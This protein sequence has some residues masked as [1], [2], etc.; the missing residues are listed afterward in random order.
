MGSE[1]ATGALA[2]V[3]H[4]SYRSRTL[5]D[6]SAGD[7]VGGLAVDYLLPRMITERSYFIQLCRRA[8]MLDTCL[9]RNRLFCNRLEN[10]GH[11]FL[12][13]SS[14]TGFWCNRLGHVLDTCNRRNRLQAIVSDT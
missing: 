13:Q 11:T 10:L 6:A 8:H 14:R 5:L 9:F 12:V 1:R 4:H 2:I 7:R 3:N